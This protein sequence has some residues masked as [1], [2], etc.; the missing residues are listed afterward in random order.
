MGPA[1]LP[2]PIIDWLNAETKKAFSA[3]EIRDRL[4]LSQGINLPLGTPEEFAAFIEADSKRWGE[5]IRRAG[6]RIEQ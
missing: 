3:G 4:F 5:V 1:R 2:R 6:I